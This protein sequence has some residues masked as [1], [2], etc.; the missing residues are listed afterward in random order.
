MLTPTTLV[1]MAFKG[2]RGER[3]GHPSSHLPQRVAGQTV[4]LEPASLVS[5]R[6][7]QV[8]LA[9]HEP[10]PQ[11]PHRGSEDNIG[12]DLRGLS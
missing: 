1:W 3:L 6:V 4:G 9:D 12:S 8:T 2:P 10:L 11:F 7:T 5:D